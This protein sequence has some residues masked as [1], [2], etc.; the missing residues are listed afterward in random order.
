MR[1]EPPQCDVI[2]IGI[3]RDEEKSLCGVLTLFSADFVGDMSKCVDTPLRGPLLT[4]QICHQIRNDWLS[5]SVCN[6]VTE[7]VFCC[8]WH[9]SKWEID[10]PEFEAKI[11]V[12]FFV[13]ICLHQTT[14]KAEEM[15]M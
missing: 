1:F 8:D 11:D 3:K 14:K 7:R 2:L 4:S 13:A 6:H 15:I 9:T 5:E 10:S 12:I